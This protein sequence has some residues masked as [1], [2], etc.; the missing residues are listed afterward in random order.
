MELVRVGGFS[1]LFVWLG[2]TGCGLQA[3]KTKKLSTINNRFMAS[4]AYG[5]AFGFRG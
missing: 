2:A 4:E 5:V 1:G 3:G